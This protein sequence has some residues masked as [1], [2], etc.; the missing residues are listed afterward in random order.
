MTDEDRAWANNWARHASGDWG[1]GGRLTEIAEEAQLRFQLE[2]MERRRPTA[3][4]WLMAND[5]RAYQLAKR[6]HLLPAEQAES[7]S[8]VTPQQV[9]AK[10][11][12]VNDSPAP[13]HFG[14]IRAGALSRH[15]PHHLGLLPPAWLDQ[16]EQ[17]P[18]PLRAAASAI[19]TEVRRGEPLDA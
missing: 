7:W 12:N 14:H 4:R 2:R 10:I 17:Q 9:R 16:L 5:A 6:M 1:K 8:S 15:A 13:M 19:P 18:T 11:R 3:F